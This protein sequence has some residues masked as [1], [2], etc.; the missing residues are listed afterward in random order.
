MTCS[1]HVYDMF[2]TCSRH[3]HDMFTS[4]LW[5]VHDMFTT[6]VWHVHEMFIQHVHNMCTTCYWHVHDVVTTCS[7]HVH[8][9]FTTCS[10][11]VKHIL[12]SCSPHV[13]HMFSTCS[14][15]VQPH[16]QPHVHH[17]FTTC[18]R[19]ITIYAPMDNDLRSPHVHY[20]S[21]STL[22]WMMIVLVIYCTTLYSANFGGDSYG[23]RLESWDPWMDLYNYQAVTNSRFMFQFLVSF[24]KVVF[25]SCSFIQDFKSKF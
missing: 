17:M 1:R 5:H 19:Q 4:C 3:V 25:C 11:H 15:Y 9:M 14:P 2:T 16:V 12:T 13:Y 21:P 24:K 6:C 20:R 8:H 7:P 18:S 23:E 10:P 22:L